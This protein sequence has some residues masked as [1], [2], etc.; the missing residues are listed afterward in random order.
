KLYYTT[1]IKYKRYIFTHA[2]LR[3]MIMAITIQKIHAIADQLQEQGIKPTLAEV[4]KALGGGSFTTISEAMKSW[5]QDNQ[6]EEQLRQVE[7]PGGITE[8]LQALGADMWQTAIDIANDRL[9]KEHEALESIKA[10]AQA[11]TDEAQEAAK[12]LESEQADLLVQLDEVTATAEAA[13]ISAAQVTA[14]R[15]MLT[16]TLSDTQH[17]LELEQAKTDAA[18]AQFAELRHTLDQQSKELNANLSKVA[19]LEATAN[20]DKAEIV[21]LQTELTATK[22]E[23][24]TVTTE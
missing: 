11:E 23:L 17:A 3:T 13:A 14:E 12:M 24:K 16:Q 6:E 19:T 22:D 4:R 1:Y 18:Q 21:R 20:S 9:V 7:L 15:D 2:K 10:K 8:R 5:R